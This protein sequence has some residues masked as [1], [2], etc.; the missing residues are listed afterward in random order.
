[1][2]KL[3]EI[4]VWSLDSE[5][6]LEKGMATHSS[7]LARRIPWIEE[8]GW[9]QSI[10]WHNQT[11]LKWLNMHTQGCHIY[12]YI[13]LLLFSSSV[14]SDSLCAHGLQHARLPCP[15]PSPRTCS[16]QTHVHRI[17]DAIQISSSV[18]PFSSCFQSFPASGSFLM[19]WL[20]ASGDQSIGALASASVPPMNIEDWFPLRLI[21]LIILQSKVLSRIFSNTT[22]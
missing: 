6:T 17:G 11:Q 10:G 14:V 8:P 18:I 20:F 7:I 9:L 19:S 3:Q 4:W 12:I 2:Q 16:V 21:G 5:D 13:L 22:A 1:M 15:S